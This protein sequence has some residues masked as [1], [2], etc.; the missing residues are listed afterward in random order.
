MLICVFFLFR[1][2]AGASG[3]SSGR[4]HFGQTGKRQATT[5]DL[6]TRLANT[7]EYSLA[8]GSGSCQSYSSPSD[9]YLLY[10]SDGGLTWA[11]LKATSKKLC[12]CPTLSFWRSGLRR[13]KREGVGGR[14]RERERVN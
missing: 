3:Q 9:V 11:S 13:R 14:E 10:S 8:G 4:L 12:F 7:V 2:F 5:V 1:F 6:D